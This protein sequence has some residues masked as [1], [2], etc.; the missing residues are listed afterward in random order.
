MIKI[1][2][3]LILESQISLNYYAAKLEM[4]FHFATEKVISR[5]M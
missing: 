4:H 5:F 3:W 2:L 1:R